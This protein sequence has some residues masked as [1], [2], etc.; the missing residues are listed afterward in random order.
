MYVAV[1]NKNFVSLGSKEIVKTR[2][3]KF[4]DLKQGKEKEKNNETPETYQNS[5][6][7]NLNIFRKIF[8]K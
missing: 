7:N 2:W 6:N 3:H 4:Q 1:R 8:I 5:D